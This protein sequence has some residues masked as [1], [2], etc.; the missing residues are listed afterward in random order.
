[1]D[2]PLSV[3][4][5][6][7][8]FAL[9]VDTV[10]RAALYFDSIYADS[11]LVEVDSPRSGEPQQLHPKKKVF[12][13]VPQL[14]K[15]EKF[16]NLTEL[17]DAGVILPPPRE[18]ISVETLIVSPELPLPLRRQ[19]ADS[20]REGASLLS[21][22]ISDLPRKAGVDFKDP[23]SIVI[24]DVS[25]LDN[26]VVELTIGFHLVSIF[27]MLGVCASGKANHLVSNLVQNDMLLGLAK[28]FPAVARA[29]GGKEVSSFIPKQNALA[30]KILE[31]LLP[32]IKVRNAAD[33]LYLR[34]DMK[35]ELVAFRTEVG[36]LTTMI[37]SEPWDS[38]FHREVQN[39]VAKEVKP[40]FIDLK[41]RLQH[42]SK[43]MLAHLV[44]DWQSIAP[45]AVA[46]ITAYVMTN[47]SLPLS[48][49]AGIATGLGIAALK[50]KVEEWSVKKSSSLTFLIKASK[51]FES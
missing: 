4:T 38:R 6:P 25:K 46:P 41:R 28:N 35:D 21:Y 22:A 40:S 47:S 5:V 43:R 16:E 13:L 51:T 37:E 9:E 48:I 17:V 3:I 26:R 7:D 19:I 2:K 18:N 24:E 10:L 31:E 30:I 33:I 44:S 20:L 11:F 49:L 15:F 8:L 32:S 29:L 36:R 1:M 34:Y 39:I 12:T 45:S 50:T 23:H 14:A 27:T 42:S